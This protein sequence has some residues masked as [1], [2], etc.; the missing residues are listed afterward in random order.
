MFGGH[1]KLCTIVELGMGLVV[2]PAVLLA[3]F[4][5]PLAEPE[6]L[7]QTLAVIAP[8]PRVQFRPGLGSSDR[9]PFVQ[10]Q[11]QKLTCAGPCTS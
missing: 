10:Q 8:C 6:R 3:S 4:E 11:L 1:L 7:A 5:A 9:R 2:A